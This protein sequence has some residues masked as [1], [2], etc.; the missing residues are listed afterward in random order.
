MQCFLLKLLRKGSKEINVWGNVALKL[1]L[2]DRILGLIQCSLCKG[3]G[4]GNNTVL[5][6]EKSQIGF[7]R[8]YYCKLLSTQNRRQRGRIAVHTVWRLITLS[9][10]LGIQCHLRQLRKFA[11]LCLFT[12]I[13]LLLWIEFFTFCWRLQKCPKLQERLH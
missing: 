12:G 1:F 2:S 11:L 3:R 5:L 10:T 6:M 4:H 8:W 9:D 7:N 13:F